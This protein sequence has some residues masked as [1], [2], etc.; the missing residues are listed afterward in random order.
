MLE[1][2]LSRRSALGLFGAT[3][4][5]GSV[6]GTLPKAKA[7]GHSGYDLS[8]PATQRDAIIRMRASKNDKVQVGWVRGNYWGVVDTEII[9]LCGLVA[10]TVYQFRQVSETEYLSAILEVAYFTDFETSGFIDEMTNPITGELIQL[11]P[12]RMGPSLSRLTHEG[13]MP[14]SENNIPGATFNNRFLP[15]RVNG[16]DV[17]LVEEI[18][19]KFPAPPGAE[20]FRYNEIT[21]FHAS[22][23]ELANPENESVKCN[24]HFNGV[25]TWRPWLKMAGHPGHMLGNAMGG[26]LNSVDELPADY[27]EWTAKYHP[28]YLEESEKALK[29]DELI[30]EL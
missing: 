10:S 3:A 27:L 4:A 19:V 20:P 16:D 22:L 30:A 12:F 29:F 11:T 17:H 26:Q 6:V 21:N 23:E 15:L 18:R 8:D 7:D 5:L 13:R 28:D 14:A 1:S 24:A 25:V 2:D 9:P